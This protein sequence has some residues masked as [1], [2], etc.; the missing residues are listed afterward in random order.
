MRTA[1]EEFKA[2]L[3]AWFELNEWRSIDKVWRDEWNS[4]KPE[5]AGAVLYIEE[6]ELF[7][8]LNG[9][10]TDDTDDYITFESLM[11]KCGV[12]WEMYNTCVCWIYIPEV[13]D[14]YMD[15]KAAVTNGL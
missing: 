15:K 5:W 14:A 7:E 11:S 9:Y 6:H 13:L 10:G 1:L 3:G 12:W 2:Q 4:D 8:L